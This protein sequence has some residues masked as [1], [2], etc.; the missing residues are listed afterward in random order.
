MKYLIL[1]SFF[2]I[3]F[4][5]CGLSFHSNLRT[6]EC[7][8]L[9]KNEV[10]TIFNDGFV[11][12]L[13]KTNAHVYGKDFG[14]LI[15]IKL[16]PDNSYRINF[17]TEFGMKIFDFEFKNEKFKVYSCLEQINKK[18]IIN[19]LEKD[20]R[21]LLTNQLT[22][23]KVKILKE[24][25]SN[26]KVLKVKEGKFKNYYFLDSTNVNFNKIESCKNL[27]KKVTV[28]LKEY[29]QGFPKTINFTHKNIDLDIRLNKI[30]Q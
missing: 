7:R 3:I 10:N 13:F 6:E 22:K 18:I 14:G 30:E 19:T 5:A 11:K 20:F 21:L 27:F 12:A 2:V 8:F 9:N 15:F 16:M 1:S 17:I 25:K 24:K 4:S 29:K 23:K 28:D 26:T